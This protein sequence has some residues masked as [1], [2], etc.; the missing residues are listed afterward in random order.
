[1]LIFHFIFQIKRDQILVNMRNKETFILGAGMTGLAAGM[2]SGLKVYEAEEV[3]GGICSSYYL[4]ANQFCPYYV[5]L[6]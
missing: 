3:P 5:I 2:I 4:K 6:I 1:M